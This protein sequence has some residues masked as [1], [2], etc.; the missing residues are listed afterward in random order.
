MK[1]GQ[2]PPQ[3]E[4]VS[5]V[6]ESRLAPGDL[7]LYRKALRSRTFGYGL[8]AFAYIRRVVEN[9]T[10]D[11]LDLIAEAAAQQGDSSDLAKRVAEAKASYQF[12]QK[13]ALAA[14]ILPASLKPGGLNPLD[15]IHDLASAGIHRFSEEECLDRFDTARTAFE[16]LFQQLQVDRAA[17]RDYVEAVNRLQQARAESAKKPAE[18]ARETKTS[19][20]AG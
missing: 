5:K 9:R 11:L 2:F 8:A 16:Y 7:D 15:A 10:N 17:A 6:L 18:A 3:A 1:V 12:D 20:S 14:E 4:R 13:V 19:N